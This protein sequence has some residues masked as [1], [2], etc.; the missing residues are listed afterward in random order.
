MEQTKEEKAALLRVL[1]NTQPRHPNE[2]ERALAPQQLARLLMLACL[3]GDAEEVQFWIQAGAPLNTEIKDLAQSAYALDLAVKSGSGASVVALLRAGA[4]S[5]LVFPGERGDKN[6]ADFFENAVRLC[7]ARGTFE[8]LHAVLVAH[9]EKPFSDRY[10][11]TEDMCFNRALHHQSLTSCLEWLKRRN[12]ISDPEWDVLMNKHVLLALETKRRYR[13][14]GRDIY[15]TNDAYVALPEFIERFAKKMPDVFLSDLFGELALNN[16][17]D[18]LKK[19]IAKGLKPDPYWQGTLNQIRE[20]GVRVK[21]SILSL[22]AL[23]YKGLAMT[24]P[25]LKMLQDLAPH[26]KGLEGAA[27]IS[28]F[29][30]KQMRVTEVLIYEKLGFSL[31]GQ[32]KR[33][34]TV[35]HYWVEDKKVVDWNNTSTIKFWFDFIKTH[36]E[37]MQ[38]PNKEGVSAIQKVFDRLPPAQGANLLKMIAGLEKRDLMQ[39]VTASDT[40]QQKKARL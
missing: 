25:C 11:L 19:L 34:N 35:A 2:S 14:T 26:L 16:D 13:L 27:P 23:G 24:S 38:T 18:L 6:P 28:P 40:P 8:V 32:D 36:L 20:D 9:Q 12:S 33:G 15:Q 17:L 29:F 5:Y 30:L 21:A 39:T 10:D 31:Q 3:N 7:F 37:L 1:S 4:H 22:A